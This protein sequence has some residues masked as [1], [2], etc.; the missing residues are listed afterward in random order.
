PVRAGH[1]RPAAHRS[2][3]RRRLR[4]RRGDRHRPR[5]QRLAPAGPPRGRRGPLRR[6]RDRKVTFVLTSDAHE[7]GELERV[8]FAALNAER[9]WIDPERIANAWAPE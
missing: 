7:A 5:G 9:A 3:P 2:R 6:A 4:R 1:W 8:R